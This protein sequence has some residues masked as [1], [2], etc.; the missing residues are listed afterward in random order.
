ML[1]KE[2]AASQVFDFSFANKAGPAVRNLRKSDFDMLD[3]LNF[4][5]P[6]SP[7]DSV[8]ISG[9]GGCHP[10]RMRGI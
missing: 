4:F 2:I 3:E 6:L 8:V 9:I 5:F 10:E 1:F 7:R